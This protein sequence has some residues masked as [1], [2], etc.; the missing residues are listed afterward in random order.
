M[1]T[2]NHYS[3]RGSATLL[4]ACGVLVSAASSAQT[5][6]YVT[7][8]I[9]VQQGYDDNLFVTADNELDDWITRV[10]PAVEAGYESELLNWSGRYSVDAESYREN[11]TL[12]SWQNSR[13]AEMFFNYRPSSRLTLATDLSYTKTVTPADLALG[14]AGLVPGLLV[15]RTPAERLMIQPSAI[16]RL[17]PATEAEVAYTHAKD[18]LDGGVESDTQIAE[19]GF[20][21]QWTPNNA[22]HYGYIFRNYE[23]ENPLAPPVDPETI[24]NLA[25]A[26]DSHTAYLGGSHDF[27]PRTTLSARVGPR[28]HDGDID[29]YVLVNLTRENANGQLDLS[30][31][32]NETTLLG[33]VGRV[34]SETLAATYT[35]NFGQNFVLQISPSAAR[36]EQT[37]FETEIYRLSTELRYRFNDALAFTLSHSLYHQRVDLNNAQQEQVSRNLVMIGF[38]LT[39]PRRA[40]ENARPQ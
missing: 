5:G 27:N 11:T 14:A 4:V 2:A 25:D 1:S 28:Y 31:E 32:L 36:V 29:P 18:E 24:L 40:A 35:Q 19:L 38:L 39:Y 30:Y 3:K 6:F 23:F 12:D 9:A 13:V 34:D 7:P 37:N 33:E 26:Q 22:L 15:G 20:E 10:T 8:S 16:Y 21:T 17:T